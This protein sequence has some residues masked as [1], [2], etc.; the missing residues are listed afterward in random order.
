MAGNG[1]QTLSARNTESLYA[2]LR[3]LLERVDAIEKRMM[4]LNL[5]F[6]NVVAHNT[7]LQEQVLSMQAHKMGHGPSEVPSGADD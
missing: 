5:A 2:A 6:T 4:A 7:A 3:V 1:K